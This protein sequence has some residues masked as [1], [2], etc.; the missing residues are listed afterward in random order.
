MKNN[1]KKKR[2]NRLSS[3][4]VDLFQ[5]HCRIWSSEDLIYIDVIISIL[6][7]KIIKMPVTISRLLFYYPFLEKYDYYIYLLYLSVRVGIVIRQCHVE[8]WAKLLCYSKVGIYIVCL[9]SVEK[10]VFYLI[11]ARIL[12]EY[13]M[14]FWVSN[15][16]GPAGSLRRPE[17]LAFLFLNSFLN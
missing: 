15:Y 7:C 12:F 4:I 3:F 9:Q 16:N 6:F 8:I 11:H 5:C 13:N 14:R 10:Q 17:T 1:N 2:P